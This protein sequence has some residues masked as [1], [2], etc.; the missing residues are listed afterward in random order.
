MESTECV[1]CMALL[2]FTRPSLVSPSRRQPV[3]QP[4][5]ARL[6]AVADAVVQA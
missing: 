6:Q 2:C 3:A 5:A 1:Q 4:R